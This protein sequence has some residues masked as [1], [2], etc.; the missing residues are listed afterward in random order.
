MIAQVVALAFSWAFHHFLVIL[1][2]VTSC[3]FFNHSCS[4]VPLSSACWTF[5][6]FIYLFYSASYLH[7]LSSISCFPAC[8]QLY[9]PSFE[10]KNCVTDF[11]PASESAVRFS[12]IIAVSFCKYKHKKTKIKSLRTAGLQ[13]C[14]F[15]A[16]EKMPKLQ[17]LW[18]R[19]WEELE[20]C[21]FDI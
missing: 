8:L 18:C 12:T 9:D 6:Y 13:G 5:F 20:I 4:L 3:Q 7:F 21:F 16:T 17:L 11:Y 2:S 14:S 15:T 10:H 19:K 1:S